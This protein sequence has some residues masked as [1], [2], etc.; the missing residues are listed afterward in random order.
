MLL[1]CQSGLPYPEPETKSLIEIISNVTSLNVN[2]S[3]VSKFEILIQR[4][5]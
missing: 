3:C 1:V 4:N 5:K 2:M